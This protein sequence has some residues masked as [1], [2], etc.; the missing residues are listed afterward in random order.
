MP[1]PRFQFRLSTLLWITLAVACFFGGMR[2]E[3]WRADREA[4]ANLQRLWTS[5]RIYGGGSELDQKTGQND[6]LQLARSRSAAGSIGRKG[7]SM[8]CFYPRK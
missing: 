1:R 4:R 8:P 7:R 3:R 6:Y 2:A 5:W